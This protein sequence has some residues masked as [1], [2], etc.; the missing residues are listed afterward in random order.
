MGQ[1]GSSTFVMTPTQPLT[2]L[3]AMQAK[4]LQ[5]DWYYRHALFAY[6]DEGQIVMTFGED[7]REVV[8]ALLR[9]LGPGALL[10]EPKEWQ[11]QIVAE[12]QHMLAAY[13]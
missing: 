6:S 8:M 9:W 13:L 1:L 10:L 7:N 12:L 11:Q 2:Q 4:R 5:Q 3:I